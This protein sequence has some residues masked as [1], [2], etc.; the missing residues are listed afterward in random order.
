MKRQR[1]IN[2]KHIQIALEDLGIG[3]GSKVGLVHSSLS[4]FGYVEGGALTVIQ[5][6]M[7]QV[8]RKGTILM[9]AFVQKI[10]GRPASYTERKKVWDIWK[11]SSDS[12]LITE[13]FRKMSGVIRSDHPTYSICA[14]GKGAKEAVIGHKTAYGRPSPWDERAFGIGS[15]WDWMYK[16]NTHYLLMGVDFRACSMLHYVQ[17][18][19]AELN[20]LYGENPP[21]WPQINGWMKVGNLL[22]ERG[23]VNQ[24]KV[25]NSV[26][27]HIR[28][29][30]LVDE[31]LKILIDNPD[32]IKKIDIAPYGSE[33]WNKSI[34]MGK[35]N[36]LDQFRSIK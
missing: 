32:M 28:T 24:T 17:S 21:Q 30:A 25:G 36:C 11:S 15:P 18:L 35:S 22:R 9:P 14:W 12:G 2:Q 7:Q 20:G 33:E 10:D 31:S 26:W 4:S 6:L 1:V 29:E 5:A 16:H 27:Y 3:I 23:L 34:R 13:T 8:S 19:Y